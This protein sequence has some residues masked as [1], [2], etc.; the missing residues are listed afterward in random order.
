MN[1]Q[2]LR[3]PVIV[4]TAGVALGLL[5]GSGWLLQSQ[6][7]E[8]PVRAALSANANVASFRLEK[9]AEGREV[10]LFLKETDHLDRT[11]AELSAELARSLK[12]TPFHIRLEDRRTPELEE[13]DSRL[14]LY[15]HEAMAT[16]R[17]AEVADQIQAEAA[18]HGIRA[19]MGV[20]ADHVYLQLHKDGAYLYTVLDRGNAEAR[21]PDERGLGL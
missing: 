11:Y 4:T 13:V 21:R 20:D 1:L 9:R 10:V 19:R 17:F 8:N 6:T 15:L 12:G 7:V 18:G 5:F 16:G 2:H 3:W 14:S